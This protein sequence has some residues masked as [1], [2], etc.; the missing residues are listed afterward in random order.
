MTLTGLSTGKVKY[1]GCPVAAVLMGTM[2]VSVAGDY[3]KCTCKTDISSDL[4]VS[5]R[6]GKEWY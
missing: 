3:A 5:K 6:N 4:L 2:S 1:Q